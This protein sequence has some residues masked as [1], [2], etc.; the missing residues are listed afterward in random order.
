MAGTV[1]H[2]HDD[3][4]RLHALRPGNRLHVLGRRLFQADHVLGI[5]RSDGDLVHVD[6]RCVQQATFFRRR[7]HGQRVRPCLGGD[8]R[9]FQR[10]ERDVDL[11][12]GAGRAAHFFADVEHGCLVPLALTD[13]HGAVDLQ[14]IEA[15]AHGFHGGGIG[16][17]LVSAAH[18][19]GC[20]HGG[21]F[22]HAHQ[23]QHQ[24]AVEDR[25]FSGI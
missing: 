4:G 2:A 11:W 12:S 22:G 21:G 20:G 19:L 8:G 7:Q 15:F 3:V 9:A 25:L 5:A 17:L 24:H 1:E 14:R 23:L 10:I 6:V 18:E 13:H 16:S